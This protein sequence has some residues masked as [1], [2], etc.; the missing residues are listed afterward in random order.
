MWRY[1]WLQKLGLVVLETFGLVGCVLLAYYLRLG[2]SP[3]RS[4]SHMI[5]KALLMAFIFQIFL[6]LRDVYESPKA[7][8]TIAFAGRLGEALLIASAVLWS[9]YFFFPGL[10]VGRGVFAGSF[11]FILAFLV[12]WHLA[13]RS[14]FVTRAPRSN[15]LVLGTGRLARELVSETLK[16]PQLGIGIQGF[17]SD[18]PELVG[19]SIM[20]PCVVGLYEDLPDL[21]AKYRVDRV[22]VEL[23]DRRGKLPVDE[24]L[25]I[26]TQGIEVEDAT[27]FYERVSGKVAI[28]NLKPSWM[29]FN[30]GFHFSRRKLAQKHFLAAVVSVLFLLLYLPFFLLTMVL[31]K[32]DSPGP[33]FHRQ[34]RVG[35]DGRVFELLKFRSMC[36]NAE[37]GIGAVWAA[38]NDPRVTR[39]GRWL[40]KFRLD[41]VPQ[42]FNV[43]KGD[44]TLV[45]PR[46]ERPE[47]VSSLEE[48]I[49]YYYLRHTVKPGVTGWAQ[50]NYQYAN[51]IEHTIE[52]L[53][54]DLFY[55][56]NMSPLLD[57]VIVF[58]TV[59]T[60]LVQRGY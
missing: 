55:I 21:V 49:P 48:D 41:E 22:V 33:I 24:L 36:E 2:Q 59:K 44:M 3:L 51:T 31:I 39:V 4:S 8:S 40:R 54:Y 18:D 17:V 26:R 19:V 35:R 32:L 60:V 7:R 37:E 45:G 6:H 34:K 10:E 20:N 5:G 23:Q 52:K 12:G 58:Q 28:E 1:L 25:R 11:L 30:P 43:I 42:L 16:K 46:P 9:L 27:S 38:E 13:L 29:I 57:A 50:I 53:Q 56:K 15:V 47:F 14:Y